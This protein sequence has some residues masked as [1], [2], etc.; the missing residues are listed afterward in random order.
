MSALVQQTN[1]DGLVQ[2]YGVEDA[3][4]PRMRV[5]A[6]DGPF[7]TLIVDFAFGDLT[8]TSG[9]GFYDADASGGSTVDSFSDAIPFIP[10][11]S[12]ITRAYIVA[13]TAWAGDG[14]IDVGLENK[15]GTALDVD[16]IF[17]GIDVDAATGFDTAGNIVLASGVGVALTSSTFDVDFNATHSNVDMYVRPI[18]D[19]TD[20]TFT[21]GTAQMV[22]EYI[23]HQV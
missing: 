15:A 13:K 3:V 1:L 7:Q 6:N 8:V 19:A 23:A 5:S 9:T 11:N 17:D 10:A 20:G 16:A 21:A 22:I 4:G 12:I 2:R 14:L 18:S